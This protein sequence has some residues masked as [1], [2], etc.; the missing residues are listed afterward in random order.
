LHIFKL[1]P[2]L[3]ADFAFVPK[4]W[5]DDLLRNL[6]RRSTEALHTAV[7][8]FTTD[9]AETVQKNQIRY[10]LREGVRNE[11]RTGAVMCG[12]KFCTM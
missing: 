10:R 11:C 2:Y 12:L 8:I 4:R 3:A 1:S 7:I 5:G 9:A 6:A